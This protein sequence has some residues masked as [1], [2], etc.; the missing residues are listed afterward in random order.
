MRPGFIRAVSIM[1]FF[2]GVFSLLLI[3]LGD[4]G[5]LRL[6]LGVL[7]GVYCFWSAYRFWPKAR[8]TVQPLT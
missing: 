7:I 5:V 6:T 1:Y 4:P 8:R 2:G 3:L